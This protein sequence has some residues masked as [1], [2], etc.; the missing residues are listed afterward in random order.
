MTTRI[1]QGRAPSNCQFNPLPYRS[2][3]MCGLISISSGE[4]QNNRDGDFESSFQ[5]ETKSV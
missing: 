3:S 4:V 5:Y 1:T 2:A